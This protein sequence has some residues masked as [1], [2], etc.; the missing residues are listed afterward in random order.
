MSN[1]NEINKNIK[2]P[3]PTPQIEDNTN[4]QST[5]N[6]LSPNSALD[7]VKKKIFEMYEIHSK[8]NKEKND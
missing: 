8:N 4:A 3:L 7:I 5:F 6:D 2:N 1:N